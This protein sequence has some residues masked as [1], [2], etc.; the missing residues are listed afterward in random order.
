MDFSTFLPWDREEIEV[1]NNILIKCLKLYGEILSG[2]LIRYYDYYIGKDIVQEPNLIF[3]NSQIYPSSD[4]VIKPENYVIS[5]AAIKPGKWYWEHKIL[6]AGDIKIGIAI[7]SYGNPLIPSTWFYCSN[8]TLTNKDSVINVPTYGVNDVIG[9]ALDTEKG[10]LYFSKNNMFM[11]SFLNEM[12][13]FTNLYNSEFYSC[14]ELGVTSSVQVI[15]KP[16]NYSVSDYKEG[17]Y[18]YTINIDQGLEELHFF[19]DIYKTKVLKKYK[20]ISDPYDLV[21]KIQDIKNFNREPVGAPAEQAYF[22]NLPA[23][24]KAKGTL[25]SLRKV[26][27]LFGINIEII[28]WYSEEYTSSTYQ[29]TGV[30]IRVV[31]GGEHVSDPYIYALI[32]QLIY[33]VIDVCAVVTYLSVYKKIVTTGDEFNLSATLSKLAIVKSSCIVYDWTN[34]RPDLY[35]FP[36][37]SAPFKGYFSGREA[38][39]SEVPLPDYSGRYASYCPLINDCDKQKNRILHSFIKDTI[40]KVGN[41]KN[42]INYVTEKVEEGSYVLPI[43]ASDFE[44]DFNKLVWEID[45]NNTIENVDFNVGELYTLKVGERRASLPVSNPNYFPSDISEEMINEF[46][47]PI[48]VG[49]QDFSYCFNSSISNGSN[50]TSGYITFGDFNEYCI[51]KTITVTSGLITDTTLPPTDTIINLISPVYDFNTS[52]NLDFDENLFED[53]NNY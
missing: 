35:N 11:S 36:Y 46:S 28:P 34:S 47:L 14:V 8:G 38:D 20:T 50:S 13:V 18:D 3:T 26:F 6:V 12:P 21:T 51:T 42:I 45:F 10:F 44:I 32:T 53:F 49:T 7:S 17:I 9:I 29:K 2:K 23:L 31:L 48:V 30:I 4:I 27:K 41:N 1:T 43:Y 19:W 24:L 40:F 39:S 5:D 15:F 37:I 22:L 25:K 33:L 52:V 16:L